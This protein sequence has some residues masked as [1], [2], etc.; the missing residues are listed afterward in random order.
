MSALLIYDIQHHVQ[1]PRKRTE[2]DLQ[3]VLSE[4]KMHT[5]QSPPPAHSRIS[6]DEGRKPWA[7]AGSNS[8][9]EV[10]LQA[11]TF[12]CVQSLTAGITMDISMWLDDVSERDSAYAAWK[13]GVLSCRCLM[14]V[15]RFTLNHLCHMQANDNRS[16]TS[17]HKA[18]MLSRIQLHLAEIEREMAST[19]AEVLGSCATTYN[20]VRQDI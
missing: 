7:A 17:Y 4:C 3:S 14:R 20:W 1:T 5:K 9:M 15:I 16:G 18:T 6:E 10:R 12:L 11:A 2:R 8:T 13:K 19:K